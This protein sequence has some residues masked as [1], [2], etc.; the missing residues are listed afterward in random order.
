MNYYLNKLPI[1]LF[2]Y[3]IKLSYKPQPA[4]L[5][6]DIKS[7]YT[8]KEKIKKYYYHVHQVFLGETE[9][10]SME[11]VVNDLIRYMN[12]NLPTILGYSAKMEDI[13]LRSNLISTPEDIDLY[14][15]VLFKKPVSTQVNILL[16]LLIPKERNEINLH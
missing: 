5:L 11:W 6:L 13:L 12:C 7:Y 3:I 10:E 1:E 16:G 9:Q 8:T 15:F 4:S 2:E 14:F